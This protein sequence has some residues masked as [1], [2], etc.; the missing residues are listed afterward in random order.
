[1][2]VYKAQ[3]GQHSSHTSAAVNKVRAGSTARLC[4]AGHGDGCD[5]SHWLGLRSHLCKVASSLGKG[6]GYLAFTGT[7]VAMIGPDSPR[8]EEQVVQ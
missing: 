3:E 7:H 6:T 1:M 5:C 2:S 4:L 8:G